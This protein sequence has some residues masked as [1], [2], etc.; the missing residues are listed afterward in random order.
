MS[1]PNVL[2]HAE[3]NATT[4]AVVLAGGFGRLALG[5]D[6]KE[7]LD[8]AEEGPGHQLGVEK[9]AGR[10]GAVAQH[11]E[12]VGGGI[13]RRVVDPR[14]HHDEGVQEPLPMG[15][16]LLVDGL[17]D[18]GILRRGVQEGAAAEPG[19]LDG[20]SDRVRNG[21]ESVNW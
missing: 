19:G 4:A 18:G 14:H 12:V 2:S 6:P 16:D 8:P 15:E 9:A 13:R 20:L 11:D 1:R 7:S 3:I 21:Q 5:V 10:H 17:V